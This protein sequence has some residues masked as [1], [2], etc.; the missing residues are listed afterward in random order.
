MRK[1]FR[2]I[3]ITAAVVLLLFGAW[4]GSELYYSHSI[5]PR[6]VSTVQDYFHKFGEPLRV[7]ELE[8]DGKVYFEFTGRRPSLAI[9]AMPSAPPSYVFEEGG[10]FV[11]WCPDRGE[12]RSDY[13]QRWPLGVG[14]NLEISIVRK[15]FGI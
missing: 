8:R 4:L 13:K 2:E 11:E 10:T 1:T 7:R 14:K 3:L 12:T 5:S 15:K 9:F 6:G